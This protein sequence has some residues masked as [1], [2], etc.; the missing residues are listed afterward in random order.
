M[1]EPDHYEVDQLRKVAKWFYRENPKPLTKRQIAA[2]LHVEI[3]AVTRMLKQARQQKIVRIE[4]PETVECGEEYELEHYFPHLREIITVPTAEQ[5]PELLN[6]WGV[7]A[8]RYFDRVTERGQHHVGVSGGETL[9]HFCESLGSRRRENIHIHTTALIGRGE[10][11]ASA[12]HVDPNVNATILWSKCGRVNGHCHYATV[13]PYDAGLTRKQIAQELRKLA[14]RTPIREVIKRMD[15]ITVAFA[16]LGLVNPKA[17]P[18]HINQL[19]MT[20]LLEPIITG[21]LAEEGAFA[22]L[23]YCLLDRDG[24][25]RKEWTFFLTAGHCD[26]DPLRH[27]L[28][29]FKQMVKDGKTVVVIAGTRKQDAIR[30]ALKSEAFNVWITDRTTLNVV[31]KAEQQERINAGQE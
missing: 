15:D 30:A 13:P 11:A 27:G 31:Y 9:L 5:Y 23:A 18:R 16:G 4:I 2:R 17:S 22:D 1:S 29:F 10:L 3:R 8:A 20:G 28:G 19:T 26:D 12:S 7:E 24:H 6:L 25:A 14:E 21:T